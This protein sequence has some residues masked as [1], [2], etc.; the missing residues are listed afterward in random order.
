MRKDRP[1]LTQMVRVVSLNTKGLNSPTKSLA[2]LN[3]L[4][5]TGA[6]ISLLQ[7]THLLVTHSKRMRSRLFPRQFFAS[8]KT[9]RAGVAII[10]IQAFEGEVIEVHPDRNCRALGLALKIDSQLYTIIILCAPNTQQEALS[11]VLHLSGIAIC[12]G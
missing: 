11:P 4:K 8:R 1:Q 3:L 7:A 12:S 10:C 5:T 9:K 6:D 2:F